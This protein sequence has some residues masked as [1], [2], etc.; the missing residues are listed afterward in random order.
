MMENM[1][2]NTRNVDIN[3]L[4][5]TTTYYIVVKKLA[6]GQNMWSLIVLMTELLMTKDDHIFVVVNN[7]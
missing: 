6:I 7:F 5:S 2:V 1:V 3:T 4:V